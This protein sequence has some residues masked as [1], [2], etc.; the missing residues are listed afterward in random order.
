MSLVGNTGATSVQAGQQRFDGFVEILGA[1]DEGA[2]AHALGQITIRFLDVSR[3]KEYYRKAREPWI[4]PDRRTEAE[5]IQARHQYVGQDRIR[6]RTPRLIESFLAISG[7]GD[8][9]PRLLQLD[10]QQLE[11]DRIIVHHQDAAA[12]ARLLAVGVVGLRVGSEGVDEL[13]GLDRFEQVIGEADLQAP[14][15]FEFRQV[16]DRAKIG[17]PPPPGRARRRRE[18]IEAIHVR[19]EQI[20]EDHLR[21]M[22]RHQIEGGPAVAGFENG[23]ILALQSDPDHFRVSRFSSTTRTVG[24][25][26]RGDG[27]A[28]DRHSS[29]AGRPKPRF[30]RGESSY[31]M[32]GI[33]VGC[34]YS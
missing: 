30:V 21:S 16:P 9:E 25:G 6:R 13:C 10:L 2:G 11:L 19:Q 4:L 3:R 32:V 12:A 31:C 15:L 28:R 8:P 24:G 17:I 33:G 14:C 7:R 20:L 5:S 22:A 27:F 34:V 29:E 18:K 26:M 1:E 23:V